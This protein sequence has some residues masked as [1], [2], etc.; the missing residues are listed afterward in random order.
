MLQTHSLLCPTNPFT[1]RPP[2][3]DLTRQLIFFKRLLI[4]ILVEVFDYQIS[5][6]S[7][8]TCQSAR[9]QRRK[10]PPH[11]NPP[12]NPPARQDSSNQK[13]DFFDDQKKSKVRVSR[14]KKRQVM[15]LAPTTKGAALESQFTIRARPSKPKRSQGF[16][17]TIFIQSKNQF[18]TS[19]SSIIDLPR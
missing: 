12:R 10:L 13:F 11:P 16:P 4:L 1:S 17:S 18:S 3:S 19:I 14:V 9:C 2:L 5:D 8:I 15:G 7:T 6:H